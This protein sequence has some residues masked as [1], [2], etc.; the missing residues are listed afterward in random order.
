LPVPVVWNIVLSNVLVKG[1][2][3]LLS[4]PLIYAVPEM[5]PQKKYPQSYLG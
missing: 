4:L 1:A 2:T 3:T 5:H